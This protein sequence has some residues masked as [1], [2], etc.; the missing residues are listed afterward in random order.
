MSRVSS[1]TPATPTGADRFNED[2]ATYTVAS[3]QPDLEAARR[4][5][6]IHLVA[7]RSRTACRRPGSPCRGRALLL[8]PQRER[9]VAREA[10]HLATVHFDQ[11][12]EAAEAEVQD[13]LHLLGTARPL[14]RAAP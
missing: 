11:I 5:E 2:R 14:P 3:A 6:L 9:R 4:F 7:N 8:A 12:G 10:D 13:L 1:G